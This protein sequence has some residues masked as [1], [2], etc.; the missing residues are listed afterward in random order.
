MDR[1][2]REAREKRDIRDTVGI[3]VSENGHGLA[4]DSVQFSVPYV[5]VGLIYTVL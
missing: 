2:S 3:E 1:P 4:H 5:D